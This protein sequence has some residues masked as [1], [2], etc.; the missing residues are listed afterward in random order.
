MEEYLNEI[1]SL[2][3]LGI[4]IRHWIKIF[5]AISEGSTE[6]EIDNKLDKILDEI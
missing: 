2:D 6:E 3:H 1:K 4:K 5:K